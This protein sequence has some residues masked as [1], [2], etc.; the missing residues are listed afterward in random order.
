MLFPNVNMSEDNYSTQA[1]CSL[2][3]P[4]GMEVMDGLTEGRK[5]KV[6]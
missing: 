3:V 1:R 2:Q 4:W 5:E 6:E